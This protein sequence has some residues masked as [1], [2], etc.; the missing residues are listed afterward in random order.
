M[1]EIVIHSSLLSIILAALTLNWVAVSAQEI[2][3]DKPSQEGKL[4]QEQ[5]YL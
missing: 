4:Q 5:A 3:E 1:K 2:A